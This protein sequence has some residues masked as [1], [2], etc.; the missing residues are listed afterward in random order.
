MLVC[1]LL[2]ADFGRRPDQNMKDRYAA[3]LDALIKRIVEAKSATKLKAGA[4]PTCEV[5]LSY[6]WS[7]SAAAVANGTRLIDGALG[8]VDPRNVDKWLADHGIATWLD[9]RSAREGALFEEI[10]AGIRQCRVLIAFVSD[11]Y[12]ASTNCMREFHFAADNLKKPLILCPV[13]T[14]TGWQNSQIALL[15]LT[16][17]RIDPKDSEALLT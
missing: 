13:G 12:L 17:P 8:D 11:E 15:A 3:Q 5:F 2:Y 16:A 14:G 7:N 4:S 6:C 1:R 10:S 9:I